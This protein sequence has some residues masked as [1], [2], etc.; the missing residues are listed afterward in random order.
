M[1]AAVTVTVTA[2]TMVVVHTAVTEVGPVNR[3]ETVSIVPITIVGP[4]DGVPVNGPEAVVADPDSRPVAA[5]STDAN[6]ETAATITLGLRLARQQCGHRKRG[7]NECGRAKRPHQN[8]LFHIFSHR[9]K[10]GKVVGN[11]LNNRG[12]SSER[13]SA[14]T[15]GTSDCTIRSISTNSTIPRNSMDFEVG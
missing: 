10:P 13:F 12:I 3:M 14:L 1:S 15:H 7:Y 9:T 8:V 2:A 6:S 5:I 11:S 4:I